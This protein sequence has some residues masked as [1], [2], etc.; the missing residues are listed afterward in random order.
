MKVTLDTNCFIDAFD[1]GSCLRAPMKIV[2]QAYQDKRII[3][4]VSL[5][6]LS[7]LKYPEGAV[8]FAKSCEILPHFPIGSWGEQIAAWNEVAGTW[9]EARKNG[10]LQLE[11]ENLSKSGNDIRD[12]GAYID[13]LKANVDV[14][15]TSDKHFIASMPAKRIEDRFGL[16]VLTPW[17]LITYV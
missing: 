14:F 13:A 15:V 2:L 7:Q 4:T 6:T 1:H 10:E 16:K 11:L 12:R 8:N 3:I 17:Q 5:H 9:D